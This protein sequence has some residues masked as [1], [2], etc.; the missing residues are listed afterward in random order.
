M[1]KGVQDTCAEALNNLAENFNSGVAL[2]WSEFE[3]VMRAEQQERLQDQELQHSNLEVLQERCNRHQEDI[4]ELFIKYRRVRDQGNNLDEVQQVT[5][6]WLGLVHDRLCH[7]PPNNNTLPPISRQPFPSAPG[8]VVASPSRPNSGLS[9]ASVPIEGDARGQAPSSSGPTSSDP[10]FIPF[11]PVVVAS[12]NPTTVSSSDSVA[13]PGSEGQAETPSPFTVQEEELV[14]ME[15]EDQLM[16][17]ET[18]RRMNAL[19]RSCPG[20]VCQGRFH[21]RKTVEPYPH[22]MALGD[23]SKLH[24]DVTKTQLGFLQTFYFSK[25]HLIR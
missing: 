15:L 5:N 25:F 12:S 10:G 21:L 20:G 14:A 19:V 24:A 22:K 7:C 4:N 6:H 1:I 8:P 23:W 17:E 13:L 9:Y 11:H 16:R 18:E 2:V 3:A